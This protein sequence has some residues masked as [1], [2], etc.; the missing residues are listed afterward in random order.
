MAALFRLTGVPHVFML[1]GAQIY[2][3][4]SLNKKS[5]MKIT[6]YI[7]EKSVV[8]ILLLVC[9]LHC[10]LSPYILILV[11]SLRCFLKLINDNLSSLSSKQR[12][13]TVAEVIDELGIKMKYTEN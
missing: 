9:S 4:T 12:S 11:R 2:I 5:I 6:R 8:C 7:F 1:S 3:P 10:T 13:C